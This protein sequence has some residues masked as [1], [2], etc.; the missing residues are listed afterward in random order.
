MDARCEAVEPHRL[1]APQRYFTDTHITTFISRFSD[2]HN[3]AVL[4]YLLLRNTII[5]V[6]AMKS[7]NL[8][9]LCDSDT[10]E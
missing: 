6:F 7:S 10:I 3:V 8:E 2:A 5:A 1:A 4:L 9:L